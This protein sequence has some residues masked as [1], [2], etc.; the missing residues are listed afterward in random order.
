LT[1]CMKNS[2][3]AGG[4]KFKLVRTAFNVESFIRRLSWCI[5]VDFV[6]VRS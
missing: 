6:A 4:V 2:I 5:S 3:N 1:P